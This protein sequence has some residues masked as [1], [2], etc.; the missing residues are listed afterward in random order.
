[1]SGSRYLW[2][3]SAWLL[4]LQF[5]VVE[6]VAASR[7][8]GYSRVDDVISDLGTAA[9]PAAGLM[10]ASFVLQGVLIAAGA[11]VLTPVL[12]TSAGRAARLLLVVAGL[13]VALVGVAPSDTSSTLHTFGAGGYLFGGAAGLVALA[14]AVRPRSEALGTTLALA[15]LLGFIG[16]VFFAT[17]VH[18][19]LG[20]GGTERL[21][22][23]VVPL[24][25]P[26]TGVVLWRMGA[27]WA[28]PQAPREG[29]PLTKR[30]RRE[31]EKAE[32]FDRARARDE[33]LEAAARRAEQRPRPA[34]AEE[35][36]EDDDF[37]VDNPWGAR[38]SD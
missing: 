29:A 23:Y 22:A 27:D 25:L 26:L 7:F 31:L 15:G 1:V 17:G 16:T 9:S 19:L 10:N 13:G 20:E 28:T 37:D 18:N 11:L 34:P 4:T 3:G 30:Q 21:A 38:R 5:F 14:Y 32:A 6:T 36:A 24:A 35:Q 12:A 2:G 8:S 33:A